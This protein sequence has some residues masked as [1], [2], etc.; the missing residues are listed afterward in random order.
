[1][2]PGDIVV[3][4]YAVVWLEEYHHIEEGDEHAA[5]ATLSDGII[6]EGDIGL[7]ITVTTLPPHPTDVR[8]VKEIGLITEALVLWTTSSGSSAAGWSIVDDLL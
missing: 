6:N 5:T 7:V 2:V 3:Y 4:K 8:R 1:M